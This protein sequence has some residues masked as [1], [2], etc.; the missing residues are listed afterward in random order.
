MQKH[1]G[2]AMAEFVVIAAVLV[3]A[4]LAMPMLGKLADVNHTT[5][6]AS[7][8]A[9]WEKT[10]SDKDHKSD[11]KLS[12]EIT[13]RFLADPDT[14][15]TSID[16]SDLKKNKFWQGAGVGDSLINDDSLMAVYS[17]NDSIPGNIG[18]DKLS[19]AMGALGNTLD[20]LIKNAN[21]DVDSKGFYKV[22][23]SANLSANRLTKGAKD[24]NGKETDETGGCLTVVGAILTDEWSAG[25]ASHVESR[26]R[27]MVPAGVAEKITDA[28]SIVGYVPLFKELKYLKDVF[29]QVQPDVLPKDRY[30]DD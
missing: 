10:V 17:Q 30:G 14:T 29:G 3:P 26:V 16:K 18:A 22:T 23:L 27:S 12:K 28:I 19:D 9:V 25:S 11:A 8:Y 7:R 1:K 4:F 20:G 15:I 24:C 13:A 21:W 5:V 6:Q 2:N